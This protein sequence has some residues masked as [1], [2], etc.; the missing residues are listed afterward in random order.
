M[1]LKALTF[2]NN[3]L[4]V[5]NI[6]TFSNVNKCGNAGFVLNMQSSISLIIRYNI[7]S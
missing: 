4:K 1:F 7:S 6:T 3:Q 5:N 2:V